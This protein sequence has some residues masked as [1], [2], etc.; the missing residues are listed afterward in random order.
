MG[1][2]RIFRTLLFVFIIATALSGCSGQSSSSTTQS[3]Q[4]TGNVFVLGTD[5]SAPL[6]TVIDFQAM[7]T[8]VKLSDGTTT[9]ELLAGGPQT[10]DFSRLDGLKALLDLNSVPAGSYNSVTVMLSS[11]TITFIDITQNPPGVS[12]MAGNLLTSTV[13]VNLPQTLVLNQND[14][15]GLVI[16]FDLR[17]SL[18]INNGV[19]DGNVV[20]VLKIN[21]FAADDPNVNIDEFRA[22][23]VSVSGSTFQIQGPH[24]RMFTVTTNTNTDFEDGATIADLNS[25][26]IVE[27]SGQLDRSTLNII[28]DEVEIV[29]QDHFVLGGLIT[30]VTPSSGAAN[31][32]DVFVREELPDLGVAPIGQIDSL[33]LTGAESYRI[34][35]IRLPLT[36]LLFNQSALVPGQRVAIG[37]TLGANNA[38]TVKRVVLEWQGQEGAWQVGSTNVVSGNQGSFTFNDTSLAGILVGG[39]V[40]VLTSNFTQFINLGGLSALAGANPIPVRVVG[41]MLKDP[42]SGNTVIAAARVERLQ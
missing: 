4:P 7:V 34:R 15:V 12:M 20:P 5:A 33:T 29:S 32:I 9:Q 17:D 38:L 23:V 27:V 14:L 31:S 39:P 42:I 18:E 36:A 40:K 1:N 25:N 2:A 11:P 41:L 8:S 30:A 35:F 10:V 6:P 26:T 21:A 28:A 13:T 22:G 37:G 16:D 19:V 3:N 24:G